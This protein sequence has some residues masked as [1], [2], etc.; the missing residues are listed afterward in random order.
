[1]K[2]RCRPIDEDVV[3]YL[4]SQIEALSVAYTYAICE[5]ESNQGHSADPI[6]LPFTKL[7][8][9][10]PETYNQ[11]PLGRTLWLSH[12]KARLGRKDLDS[13]V[14]DA[15]RDCG[16]GEVMADSCAKDWVEQVICEIGR[17]RF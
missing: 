9:S 7:S 8:F 17:C 3:G 4:T 5:G 14:M 12:F 2:I 15:I 16:R 1:M 10:D 13:L 6:L 11:P